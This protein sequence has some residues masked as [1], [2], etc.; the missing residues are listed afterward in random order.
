MS[1]VIEVP[2]PTNEIISANGREHRMKTAGKTKRLREMGAW[3]SATARHVQFPASAGYLMQQASLTVSVGWQPLK[4]RR[5]RLNL[6]PTLKAILDGCVDAKV[7]PDDDL[8]I[9]DTT[10]DTYH[11][12]FEPGIVWLRLEF[13]AVE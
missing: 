12:H 13:T 9:L 4:R 6:A 10:W 5:D 7:I 3:H 11:E 2:I 1:L 8:H